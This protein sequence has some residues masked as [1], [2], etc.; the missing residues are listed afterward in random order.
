MKK[1]LLIFC[2]VT[3][4]A[5]SV[6]LITPTQADVDRVS[7]QYKGYTLVDLTGGEALFEQK[8]TQCHGL[9]NPTK[10]TAD[11]W[12]EIVPK[13][14]HKAD[15]KRGVSKISSNDQQLILKYLITMSMAPKPGK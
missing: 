4:S 11:E 7:G 5:C 15:N 3:L 12:A 6:K 8:C 14:A 13:M 1:L 2:V 10:R 9:K